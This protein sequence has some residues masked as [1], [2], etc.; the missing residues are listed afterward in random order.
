MKVE[1]QKTARQEVERLDE[2]EIVLSWRVFVSI[3]WPRNRGKGWRRISLCGCACGYYSRYDI[4]QKMDQ[5]TIFDAVADGDIKL[6]PKFF[7]S[8]LAL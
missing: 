1:F 2:Y 3:L 4:F 7:L 6:I 5:I 8:L